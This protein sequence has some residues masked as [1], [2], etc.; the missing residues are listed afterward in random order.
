[1]KS[2]LIRTTFALIGAVAACLTLSSC[3]KKA[4]DEQ[5]EQIHSLRREIASLENSIKQNDG[6]KGRLSSELSTLQAQLGKCSEELAFVKDKLSRWPDCWPDWH[7]APPAPPEPP[8]PAP[9]T[10]GGKKK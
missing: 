9:D 3:A 10:K 1:M 4:T 8:A 2:S 5:L 7:P 6:E